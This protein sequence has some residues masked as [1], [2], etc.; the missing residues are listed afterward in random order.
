MFS[1]VIKQTMLMFLTCVIAR[2]LQMSQ[3]KKKKLHIIDRSARRAKKAYDYDIRSDGMSQILKQL[4]TIFT[5]S[6]LVQVL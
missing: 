1:N 4:K 3:Q 5:L 2:Y 6:F